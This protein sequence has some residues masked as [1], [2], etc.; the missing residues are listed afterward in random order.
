MS[1]IG[2]LFEVQFIQDSALFRVVGL[3]SL[4]YTEQ[5]KCLC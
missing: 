2:T 1:I 5:A 4:L 3:D